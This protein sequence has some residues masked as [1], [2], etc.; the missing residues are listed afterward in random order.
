MNEWSSVI[1]TY[2]IAI[3]SEV[4]GRGEDGELGVQVLNK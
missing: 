3:E 4:L 1:Y 2:V